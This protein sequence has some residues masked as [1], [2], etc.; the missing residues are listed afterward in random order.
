L[1]IRGVYVYIYTHLT[2]CVC[3]CVLLFFP[4]L[5]GPFLWREAN[6]NPTPICP[7]N[8]VERVVKAWS[9]FY[10]FFFFVFSSLEER[11]GEKNKKKIL[12]TFNGGSLGS[13]I[14]E[15]RSE[16]RYVMWIAEFSESSN[17]WTHIALQSNKL[18][19]VCLSVRSFS[20]AICPTCFFFFSHLNGREREREGGQSGWACWGLGF[21]SEAYPFKY[22]GRRVSL[23]GF[24]FSVKK[25]RYSPLP[26]SLHH[27]LNEK[28]KKR[29]RNKTNGY[30]ERKRPCEGT[31]FFCCLS[32]FL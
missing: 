12:T 16:L 3:V 19:H 25:K 15:E 32:F 18:Q 23:R 6:K 8:G 29:K 7:Y 27:T 22:M 28:N 24:S 4:L 21:L 5:R 26:P 2:V 20:L 9:C 10:F 14:D 1:K 11:R 31:G 13:C 30:H 17:L